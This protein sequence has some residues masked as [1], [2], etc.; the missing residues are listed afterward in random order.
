MSCLPASALA[1]SELI[2]CNVFWPEQTFKKYFGRAPQRGDGLPMVYMEN[3]ERNAWRSGVHGNDKS[4]S[5][6]GLQNYREG[7][8]VWYVEGAPVEGYEG[9]P[10]Q[11]IGFGL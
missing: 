11:S 2:Y 7:A 10:E 1:Q 3:G 6:R 5:A 4:P 9:E 8:P